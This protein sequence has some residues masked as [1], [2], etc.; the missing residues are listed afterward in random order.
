MLTRTKKH[1]SVFLCVCYAWLLVMPYPLVCPCR[2]AV[3]GTDLLETGAGESACCESG[4]ADACCSSTAARVDRSVFEGRQ[5][6]DCC[7]S[8][9]RCANC[10][11][12]K[13]SQQYP[14]PDLRIQV[15]DEQRIINTGEFLDVSLSPLLQAES[16]HAPEPIS[17]ARHISTTV[18]LC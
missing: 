17:V 3:Q 7:S 18:L 13:S 12:C 1:I 2:A 8:A 16:D 6:P 11:L 15:R 4:E 9:A 5:L 14:A 10:N